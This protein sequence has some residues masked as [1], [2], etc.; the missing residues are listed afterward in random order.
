MHQ[1]RKLGEFA[2]H[3]VQASLVCKARAAGRNGR[4]V[5]VDGHE[6]PIRA[7]R[8]ED[9]RAVATAAECR[10]DVETARSQRERLERLF[11]KHRRVLIQLP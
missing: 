5:A 9:A 7:K 8:F 2:V 1:R 6:L 3:E 11:D 10:V 4:G